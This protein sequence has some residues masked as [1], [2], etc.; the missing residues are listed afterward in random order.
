MLGYFASYVK[1][2]IGHSQL[3]RIVLRL[4]RSLRVTAGE[5]RTIFVALLRGSGSIFRPFIRSFV[6]AEAAAF[7][8]AKEKAKE[9]ERRGDLRSF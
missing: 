1:C 6:H 3:H 7:G 2:R 8:N 5:S 4:G 9:N